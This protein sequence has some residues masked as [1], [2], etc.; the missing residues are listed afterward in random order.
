MDRWKQ[1]GGLLGLVVAFT[2]IGLWGFTATGGALPYAK[3]FATTVQRGVQDGG[4]PLVDVSR[5]IV[6]AGP[7][8]QGGLVLEWVAL[9][10]L[11]STV[12]IGLYVYVD[13]TRIGGGGP[14]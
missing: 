8:R 3:R 11:L 7:I 5:G 13:R 14:R 9:V 1:Y 12:G 6:I 10:A 2:G 4:G